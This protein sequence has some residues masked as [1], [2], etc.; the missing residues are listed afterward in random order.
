[1]K[2]RTEDKHTDALGQCKSSPTSSSPI[3]ISLKTSK[4]EQFGHPKKLPSLSKNL[5]NLV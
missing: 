2:N 3:P 5:K 4:S 1:M